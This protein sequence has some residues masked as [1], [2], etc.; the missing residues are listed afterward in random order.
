VVPVEEAKLSPAPASEP[1]IVAEFREWQW[2]ADSATVA[3]VTF[4]PGPGPSPGLSPSRSVQSPPGPL[5]LAPLA[6]GGPRLPSRGAVSPWEAVGDRAASPHPLL[7]PVVDGHRASTAERQR[8]VKKAHAAAQRKASDRMSAH[9][10]DYVPAAAGVVK[11]CTCGDGMTT[12]PYIVLGAVA[13]RPTHYNFVVVHDFFDTCD[14][15]SLL[16]RHITQ[17][18]EG[19]QALCFNY[20]GQSHTT[21][22]SLSPAERD[23]GAVEPVHNNDWIADRLHELLQH[24]EAHGDVLLSNPFHLV[25]FGNGAAVAAAFCQRWGTHPSYVH[26]LKALVSVNGYLAPDPQL[27]AI[28]HSAAQLFETAPASRPDVPVA[29]W[30]RFLFSDEYLSRV[31]HTLA[32]NIYTAV[33]NPITPAGRAKIARGALQ[34]RDLRGGLAP[35]LSPRNVVATLVDT[36]A[37]AAA[38]AAAPATAATAANASEPSPDA[39][40]AAA[41]APVPPKSITSVLT[42]APVRVPVVVLQSTE[43]LL[44][45]PSHVDA[46]VAGRQTGHLWSHQLNSAPAPGPAIAPDLVPPPPD[47]VH[48]VGTTAKGVDDYARCSALGPHGLRL[49]LQ[50]VAEPDGAFV[51]WA[52]AGHCV[53]QEAKAVLLDLLDALARPSEDHVGEVLTA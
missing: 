27:R 30:S 18:R 24:A 52:R 47:R 28:L 41:T 50:S 21:W 15:T 17:R 46:F 26:S 8:L 35:D 53:Q 25:G 10:E 13:V 12:M 2:K 4:S 5:T 36:P 44:V 34:H 16:M 48:W 7:P 42:L 3:T 43:N 14:A 9:K 33:S 22:P 45:N 38:A 49:L 39:A 11:Q 40:A 32:L 29:F 19:C 37:A 31:P 6:G 20:P 1:D 51:L 23:R